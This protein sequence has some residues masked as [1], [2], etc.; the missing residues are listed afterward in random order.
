MSKFLDS[1]ALRI[2][3]EAQRIGANVDPEVLSWPGGY[4]I[5]VSLFLYAR[6]AVFTR[7]FIERRSR[8]TSRTLD[9][10][11][12]GPLTKYSR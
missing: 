10:Y 7:G 12:V 1:T 4:F 6:A 2:I 8:P 3:T 5:A 11:R 9:D